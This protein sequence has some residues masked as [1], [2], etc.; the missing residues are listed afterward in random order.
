MDPTV[1]EVVLQYSRTAE[2]L[3]CKVYDC[4]LTTTYFTLILHLATRLVIYSIYRDDTD[5]S[6]VPA[7]QCCKRKLLRSDPRQLKTTVKM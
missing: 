6:T 3:S 4:T 7:T 5:Y 1:R 2:K